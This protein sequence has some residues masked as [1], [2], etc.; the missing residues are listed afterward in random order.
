MSG[1]PISSGSLENNY[2]FKKTFMQIHR[3]IAIDLKR[4]K[5]R[6]RATERERER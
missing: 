5:K 1:K 2:D 4:Y 6:G 3:E